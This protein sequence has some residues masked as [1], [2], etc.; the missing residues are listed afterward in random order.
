[1]SDNAEV[2]IDIKKIYEGIADSVQSA[3]AVNLV[4]VSNNKPGYTRKRNGK[5]LYISTGIKS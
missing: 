3:K 5:N 2:K 1:M 4:Y